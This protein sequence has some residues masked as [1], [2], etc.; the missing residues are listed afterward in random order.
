MKLFQNLLILSFL[1]L[2]IHSGAQRTYKPSSVLAAGNFYKISVQ[3]EGVY[4]LDAAFLNSLGINGSIP[5]SQLRLYGNGGGMLPE[6]NSAIPIDDLEENAIMVFDGGDGQI[7][8][9]DYILFYAPGPH[10]WT[11]D[12]LNKRFSHKKNLYSDKAYYFITIGGTGK[13]IQNQQNPPSASLV[14]NS[15]NE[16]YFHELDSVNFLNSGKEWYGEEF[17]NAPGKTLTRQFNV[18]MP[19]LVPGQPATFVSSLV[20]R[21]INAQSSFNITINNINVQQ[22]PINFITTGIYE[23]FGRQEET[24]SNFFPNSNPQVTINYLPGSFNSQGWLNWFELHARRN[25]ALTEGQL[26]FRDW[27]S[28]N[29]GN[30]EF[31]LSNAHA[32][33]QVWDVTHPL[34]PQMMAS[35]FSGGQLRFTNSTERLREYIA[36]SDQFLIPGNEGRIANQDLHQASPKDYIILTHPDFLTQAQQLANF[37]E[38]Q[39][40]LQTIV[41]TTEQVYNEFASGTPDPTAI[42]DFVK[43]YYD[44]FGASWNQGGKYLLLFGKAS[45]DFKQRLMNNTSFVPSYQSVSSLDPLATYTS[46]DFFGF[47]EDHEDINSGLIINTLEIGIGRVPSKNLEE[48]RN[49]VDKVMDYHNPL[50][51]GPWRNNLNFIADDEDF[52]LHLQ[53]AEVLTSTVQATAPVFNPEKIYLDA[54]LQEGGSSGGRYPQANVMIDNNIF[55]GTLIWNFSG[56]GGPQRLAEEV[57]IDQSIVNKWNNR[58]KLPLFITATCDF[59]PFDNPVANSLGENLL[60]RPKTGAIALMTTT[61]VVFAFSNRI[62]NDNYLRIALQPDANGVYKTLGEAN[63]AAKNYTYQTSGDITNNRKFALLGDPAMKL[64]FPEF[65]VA[66]THLNGVDISVD[67]DTIRAAEFVSIDGEVKDFNGQFMPSF[68]GTVYLSVFDKPRT[69]T[70]LANDPTSL[71]VDFENQTDVLFRG[72]A[73]AINGKFNFKFKVPK[74]INYQYGLGKLSFYAH[75]LSKEGNGYSDNVVIGGISSNPGSDDEGPEVKAY[76]NDEK[77]V[78]GSITNANPV[79][80]LKLSDTSGINTGS[81]GIDHDIVATLD[82]DNNN[83]FILN[84]FYE[85]DLDDYTKGTVRFQLPELAPGPHSLKIKAWDVMNNSTEYILDFTVVEDGELRIDHVLN[86]PNP[87]TTRTAFWFEHNY[88][89]TDLYSKVEVFT[90]SG[91]L[92]KTLTQT[93]N[94]PGNRSMEIEWD[95]RD[96]Y[97]NKIGRGVYIYR[98]VVRSFN[99]KTAEKWERLVLL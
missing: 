23:F 11:K 49:F 57:V 13:R 59:A 87:F 64:G 99:G 40:N 46:D 60:V 34:H 98:L 6:S 76:L 79:L 95:G 2:S 65:T 89:G 1:L 20:A 80:I 10:Q 55:N 31:L 22:V 52:N 33:T 67:A 90:V 15:F 63:M 5:S 32:N 71:P 77:F 66:A 17:S 88:P 82:N 91:K 96:D 24:A 83:Y 26:S 14:V 92:I 72:K 38:Q 94:T 81:S 62:M 50:S 36:F 43:M 47:L 16:R 41:V 68:Q 75:D 27:N 37:H 74:D 70:T 12:S 3:K 35:I 45:F 61:R 25:L 53:D 28:V 19:D 9:S 84:N 4:K 86:Y 21:S 7:S 93:I 30:A 78:N 44:R 69:I 8:G 18:P 48:A 85:A 97:G 29:Q 54:F 56:H 58:Y 51:F 39:N 42:R 73:S